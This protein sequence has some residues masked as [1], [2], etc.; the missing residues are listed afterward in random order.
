VPKAVEYLGDKVLF[1]AKPRHGVPEAGV[2]A[3]VPSLYAPRAVPVAG[4]F[5]KAAMWFSAWLEAINAGTVRKVARAF[6]NVPQF[7]VP[8]VAWRMNSYVESPGAPQKPGLPLPFCP[9]WIHTSTFVAPPLFRE[10]AQE[11]TP[12]PFVSR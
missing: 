9:V 6:V 2:T 10:S 4:G 5:E 3:I 8:P 12:S 11:L 7:M 1:E